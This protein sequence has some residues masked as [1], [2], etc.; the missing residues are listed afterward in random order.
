MVVTPKITI[1]ELSVSLKGLT[2]D[3]EVCYT[4]TISKENLK[5]GY[6][7][8]YVFDFGFSNALILD[9]VSYNFSGKVSLI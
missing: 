8:N 4:N 3:E 6:S 5:E 1:K 2:E 9:K 7:Y